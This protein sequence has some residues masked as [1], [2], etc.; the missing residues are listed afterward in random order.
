M[1]KKTLALDRKLF[2][3]EKRIQAKR[4]SEYWLIFLKKQVLKKYTKSFNLGWF[5][6]LIPVLLVFFAIQY[7]ESEI[8]IFVLFFTFILSTILAQYINRSIKQSFVD[9]NTIDHL[10]KLIAKVKGDV[11][12]NLISIKLNLSKIEKNTNVIKLEELG[13]KESS[14]TKYAAYQLERYQASFRLKD[15][16]FCSASLYQIS[17]KR[18]TKK[19]GRVSGKTKIKIKHKHKFYYM[20]SL[21]LNAEQYQVHSTRNGDSYSLSIKKENG[22]HFVK[23]KLKVKQMI[24]QPELSLAQKG[25]SS[26][27]VNMIDYLIENK[28][29]LKTKNLPTP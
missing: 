26:N 28:I 11:F 23:I 8:W 14:A 2:L 10:S 21:K 4:P 12:K 29:I 17:I 5:V 15:D 16:T 1:F 19:R 22:F 3:K 9:P 24:I 18:T 20:F 7:G 13:L 25:K 6:L 27:F